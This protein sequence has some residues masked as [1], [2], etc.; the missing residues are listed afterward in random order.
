MMR[1]WSPW[2]W[3]QPFSRNCNS[4]PFEGCL[5]LA[6]IKRCKIGSEIMVK[7]GSRKEKSV[8]REK[9]L[10]EVFMVE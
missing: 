2:P 6:M 1:I 9:V 8:L 3:L 4:R 5:A 7:W 10:G